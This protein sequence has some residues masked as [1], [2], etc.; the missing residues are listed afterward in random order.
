MTTAETAWAA[1][2]TDGP[3][4]DGVRLAGLG[5]ERERLELLATRLEEGFALIVQAIALADGSAG[6]EVAAARCTEWSGPAADAF[7]GALERLEARRLA[8]VDAL[9]DAGFAL[10]T[11]AGAARQE[12]A[13]LPS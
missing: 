3:A 1:T 12:L 6:P 5:A 10:G 7:A 9:E 11:A 8:G 4:M 2:P 13:G